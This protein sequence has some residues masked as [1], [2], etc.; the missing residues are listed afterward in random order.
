[1]TQTTFDQSIDRDKSRHVISHRTSVLPY[2]PLLC[3]A[4][5]CGL[6]LFLGIEPTAPWILFVVVV[7][8][9]LGTDGIM[10][11]HPH[12][13][14][15][16]V[17]GTA[18]F[19]FL[20]TLLALASGLFLEEVTSGYWTVPA[21]L[22]AG[23]VM[24]AALYGEYA[25]AEPEGTRYS[26]A[27][28]LLNLLTYL[29]AFAFYSVLYEF[30][31]E[32]FP[33]ALAVGLFSLLLAIEI[34]REAEADAYRALTFASVIGLI[35]AEMRWSLYFIPLEGF[36]AAIL[37]LLVF[38]LSTGLIQHLLTGHLSRGIAVEFAVVTIIGITVVVVGDA[39]ALG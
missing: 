29:A 18:P 34:F 19:L 13:G 32:L 1:M 21:V 11:S 16:S 14:I 35:V 25:S 24:G 7:L 30:D 10:R 27:R 2:I 8:V 23:F 22:G 3:L 38:Y 39:L 15:R 26:Q 36:L 4:Y 28:F 5:M 17:T 12:A 37:L 33:G 20:P 6:A 9:G 31:I